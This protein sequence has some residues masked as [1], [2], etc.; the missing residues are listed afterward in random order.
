MWAGLTPP[1]KATYFSCDELE[2]LADFYI[3]YKFLRVEQN[4]YIDCV[5]GM[6]GLKKYIASVRRMSLRQFVTEFLT[7]D[8]KAHFLTQILM[9]KLEEEIEDDE[10]NFG[11]TAA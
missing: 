11:G 8:E 5:L 6:G 10:F 7:K 1:K 3:A 2:A 9:D 4:A